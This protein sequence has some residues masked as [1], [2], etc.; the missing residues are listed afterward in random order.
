MSE[1]LLPCPFCGSKDL[2]IN[3]DTDFSI[4]YVHC[5][6]CLCEGRKTHKI[7]WVE[8]AQE[9]INAWNDRDECVKEVVVDQDKFDKFVD[10]LEKT[11][12]EIKSLK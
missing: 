5:R 8:S 10:S 11:L 7:G 9:A 4:Y 6:D 3:K 12:K 2:V 1:E